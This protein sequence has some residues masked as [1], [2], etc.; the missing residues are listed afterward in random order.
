MHPLPR[1][2]FTLIELLVV[3]AIIGALIGLLLPAIQKVREIAVRLQCKNNLKQLG[4]AL[5]SCHDTIGYL[6]P[7]MV[8]SSSNVSDADA[9]GFTF[10]LPYL[11]EDTTYKLYHFDDP[12]FAPSNYQ[13]VSV[14]VK[15][16]FCPANRDRG[17]LDLSPFAAQWST[18]LPPVAGCCDYVF[19]K[20]ANGSMSADWTRIPPSTVGV[21]NVLQ[22]GEN[23]LRLGDIADGTSQT[24]AMG[25]GTAGTPVYYV[26][27]LSNPSQPVI[28][29]NGLPI[30][31]EQSWSAAGVGDTS[32]PFYGSVFGVTAQYG[33]GPDPR[34]EPM[35]R[36]PAT[37]TVASGDPRGDNS[38]G[39]DFVTGFRS[40]HPGGCNFLFCDGSV[41]FE[42]ESL[43]PNVYRALS[44]YAGGEVFTTVDY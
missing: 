24:F 13:A 6:P 25:D 8:V 42:T 10:L 43:A 39:K 35:N 20:G 30:I 7:G 3:M 22:T 29:L 9:T 11:E 23:G 31:L 1:R 37:P 32:H 12:W 33:L 15:V 41:R 34:D 26:R 38:S 21:F 5:H 44:T 28:G 4:L 19:C 40:R 16:F 27:S 14:A 36:R 18:Q 17:V 2:G